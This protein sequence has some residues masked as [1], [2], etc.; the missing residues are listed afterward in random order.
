MEWDGVDVHQ[1]SSEV[2]ESQAEARVLDRERMRGAD[3]VGTDGVLEVVCEDDPCDRPAVDLE[4]PISTG[5]PAIAAASSILRR[6]TV[7]KSARS[8]RRAGAVAPPRC[9]EL[10]PEDRVGPGRA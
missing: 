5:R 3:L 4:D 9:R 10:P 7:Q 8:T 6:R 1:R 2:D